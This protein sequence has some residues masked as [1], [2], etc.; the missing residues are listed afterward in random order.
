MSARVSAVEVREVMDV[1]AELTNLTPY[2]NLANRFTTATLASAGLIEA[3]LK[4]I[5]LMLSCHFITLRDPR[6]AS[7]GVATVSQSFQYSVGKGLEASMYGQQA[8]MIDT[9]GT[10]FRLNKKGGTQSA[11]FKSIIHETDWDESQA[12]IE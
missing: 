2:I 7:E 9:S 5:E 12:V 3:V 4:D 1:A 6:V 10:L 8:M 11:T